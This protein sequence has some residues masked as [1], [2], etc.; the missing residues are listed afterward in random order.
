[1]KNGPFFYFKYA[2]TF[3]AP[4]YPADENQANLINNSFEFKQK[5][6]L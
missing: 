6:R 1:M 3:N 5:S 2:L 4:P